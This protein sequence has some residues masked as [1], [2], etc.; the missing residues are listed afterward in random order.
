MLAGNTVGVQVPLSAPHTNT[1]CFL[2]LTVLSV[3]YPL[4]PAGPDSAGGAEQILALLERGIIHA[5][6]RSVVIAARGSEVSGHLIPTSPSSG[7]ITEAQ[8]SSA[9]REHLECINTA[10]LQY[11]IDLIHFHGLDFNTYLPRHALPKLATLHLPPAWY[12][13]AIFDAPDLHLNCVS[14]TQATTTPG[15]AKLPVVPNGI[16]LQQYAPAAAATNRP[17]RNDLLWIGRICPEKAVHIALELAHSLDLPAVVAGPVHPFHD[18]QAYFS[19]RVQPLLDDRRR[20]VG[21]IGLKQKIKLL[22]EARCLLIPSVVA[23]TSSLVAMEAIGSG[24]PVI[25]FRSGAL[26]EV[27][28]HGVTGFL[29]DSQ[30]EMADAVRRSDDISPAT[31]RDV[32]NQRF[33]AARMVNDYLRLYE[34]LLA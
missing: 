25:A 7:E 34:S 17:V 30:D 9:Q 27:I 24:T 4:L 10:L 20:H 32:A 19:K 13:P 14:H 21:P 8:R 31:C 3:A 18:H 11:R 26:P 1:V 22:S 12:P 15:K 5:G 23:E 6:H 2:A 33:D 28:D 16:D 29:V